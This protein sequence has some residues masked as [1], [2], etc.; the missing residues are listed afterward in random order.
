[1]I[2]NSYPSRGVYGEKPL[3]PP[4]CIVMINNSCPSRGVYGEKPLYPPHCIGMIKNSYLSRVVYGE[5][6]FTQSV[7]L[8]VYVKPVY[9]STCFLLVYQSD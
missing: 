8:Y 4:P 9:T 5:N 6:H 2:K 7:S 1:M 3:Y